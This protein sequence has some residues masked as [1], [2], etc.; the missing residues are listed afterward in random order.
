[1]SVQKYL[2][3]GLLSGLESEGFNKEAALVIAE[4]IVKEYDSLEKQALAYMP[5]AFSRGMNEGAS[6]VFGGVGAAALMGAGLIGISKVVNRTVT[7]P[8][9]YSKFKAAVEQAIQK[10]QVLQH[11]DK[12]RVHAIADSIFKYAPNAGA[13][14]NLLSSILSNAVMMDGIDPQ[15]VQSLVNLEKTYSE[16]RKVNIAGMLAKG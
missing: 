4:E 2:H 3:E 6:K 14:A 8:I 13:D 9:A 12:A 5:V 7:Q 1:M 10:N 16:S 11:A 15:V